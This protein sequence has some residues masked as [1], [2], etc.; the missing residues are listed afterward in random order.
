MVWGFRRG[1]KL[2]SSELIAEL[3]AAHTR[4]LGEDLETIVAI[5][6]DGITPALAGGDRVELRGFG[7]LTV[8]RRDLR[9]GCNPR[10]GEVVSVE[11]KSVPSFKA[12]KELRLRVDAGK[13]A[14]TKRKRDWAV[15]RRGSRPTSPCE[16]EIFQIASANPSQQRFRRLGC[17]LTSPDGIVHRSRSISEHRTDWLLA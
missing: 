5:I 15:L 3:S 6:C 10:N 17:F 1:L 7:A 16:I 13:A 4:V 9:V 11:A 12:E 2:T 8:R 14:R